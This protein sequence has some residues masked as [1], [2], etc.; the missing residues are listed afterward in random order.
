M[1]YSN[2]A[3]YKIY[4]VVVSMK[5][6]EKMK[7]EKYILDLSFISKWLNSNQTWKWDSKKLSGALL[8]SFLYW[9]LIWFPW[10]Y[11]WNNEWNYQSLK[12]SF[13]RL[14]WPY[15]IKNHSIII[16]FSLSLT[17]HH[18]LSL[19]LVQFFFCQDLNHTLFHL[20][21]YFCVLCVSTLV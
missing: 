1:K 5:Q 13:W 6:K 21:V 2:L 12:W 19:V 17:C 16:Q 20:R 9:T 18:L 10:K 7:G 4:E 14:L 15:F 3:S 11:C 8:Y